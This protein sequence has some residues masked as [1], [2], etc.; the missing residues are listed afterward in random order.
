LD[1]SDSG[2][3]IETRREFTEP[4]LIGVV[5]DTHL[6]PRNPGNA[7]DEVAALFRR[8]RVDLI[9]HAGDVN[10][11][12]ALARLSEVAPLLVVA[13][14]NDDA[15]VLAIAPEEIE[16]S[17]GKKRFALMHGH[18]GA[19]ARS[20]AKRRFSGKV[21]CVIYGHSH[22]PMIEKADETIFFNPGSAEQ[23]RWH[24]HFGLGLIRVANDRIEPELILWEHPREL[25][26]V[27]PV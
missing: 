22:I 11:M 2:V 27:D 12:P 20:E 19:S 26:N 15:H 5:S 9:A 6:F 18:G 24:P 25:A 1:A 14:N 10:S 21:D 7:L 16:F 23:R 8:F 17:V 4:F 13:G 3:L